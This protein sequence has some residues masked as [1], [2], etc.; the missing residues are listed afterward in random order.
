L[1]ESADPALLC[2]LPTHAF[3]RATLTASGISSPYVCLVLKG[4]E[5]LTPA[6]CS[7]VAHLG[8]RGISP[9][10][11]VLDGK[12]DRAVCRRAARLLGAPLLCPD[13]DE[14]LAILSHASLTLTARL[15]AMILS[16]SV[17]TPAVGISDTDPKLSSFAALSG[18]RMSSPDALADT[19][20]EILAHAELV[21]GKISART[22]TL[23]KKAQKDLEML[24]E[25]L[26]NIE[27]TNGKDV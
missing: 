15:H 27:R 24:L 6:L 16:S 11:L 21:R 20:K 1:H 8:A 14:L 22:D 25:M 9:V 2:P 19:A 10:L 7:A 12:R 3:V 13:V 18:Q 23:R 5:P 4:G 26:Y 17:S